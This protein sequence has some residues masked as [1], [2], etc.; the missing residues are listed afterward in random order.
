MPPVLAF[1]IPGCIIEFLEDSQIQTGLVLEEN[2][3]K[4]RVILPNRRETKLSVGRVLPW[5][6]PSYSPATTRDEAAKILETHR[7]NRKN[8]ADAINTESV[9]ELAAEEVDQAPAEW[10]AELFENQP[11]Y[12]AIASYGRAL[13]NDKLHFKFNNG[14]FTVYDKETAAK[15]KE[16]L[17]KK[18]DRAALVSQGAEL[19]RLLFNIGTQKKPP[20]AADSQTGILT[21][22]RMADKLERILRE[23]LQNPNTLHEEETWRLLTHGLPET[24]FLAIQL[25]EAWGKIPPHY[26]FWLD[27]VAYGKNEWWKNFSEELDLIKSAIKKDS[28]NTDTRLCDFDFISI[29]SETTRDIDDAFFLKKTSSGWEILLAFANPAIFWPFGSQLDREVSTRA[30][31]LYLPEETL[32]LLPDKLGVDEFSLWAEKQRHALCMEIKLSETGAIDSFTPFLA[33]VNLKSNLAYSTAQSLIDNPASCPNISPAIGE[34]LQSAHEL[35]QMLEASRIKKGAVIMNRPEVEIKLTGENENVQVEMR[36]LPDYP[37]SHR[38][39]TEL[40][41]LANSAIADWG[42]SHEIPLIHRTQKVTLPMDYA[43]VWT[44]EEDMGKIMKAMIPSTLE[45]APGPHA[46]LAASR[47]APVSS[48]L[49][50]YADLLNEAQ[51]VTFLTS[52]DPRWSRE[53]LETALNFHHPYLESVIQVQKYRPRYWKLL[54]F[55][56][57]GEKKWWRAIITEENEYN[58]TLMLPSHGLQLRGKR[59]LF[60][61]RTVPGQEVLV[62]LGKINPLYNEIAVLETREP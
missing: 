55:R 62:R 16:E 47:Y 4:L 61:E 48:P 15:R 14:A 39:V 18:Q 60:G 43:G 30:T 57:Q 25:L 58:V 26:N 2:A 37:D 11:D 38:I 13:L 24:P 45:I 33:N 31:S 34:M 20:L 42:F 1:P 35:A 12:D 19:F 7:I 23:H 8:R 5:L 52:G 17:D 10:F 40:M 36:E 28:D 6:G 53:E 9:W 49:R 21:D 46:G 22:E 32:H 56:Q 51:I 50:R 59:N 3:G 41:V 29:D 44:R 54:Y 27:R